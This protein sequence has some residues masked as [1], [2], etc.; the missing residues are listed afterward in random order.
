MNSTIADLQSKPMGRQ[1][2]RILMNT[3]E[4]M[5]PS[6]GDATDVE[7]VSNRIMQRMLM[8]MPLR[9]LA[10]LSGSMNPTMV[11][12]MVQVANGQLIRGLVN[13]LRGQ[14][15]VK[16]AAKAQPKTA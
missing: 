15:Q 3:V 12:G 4:K 8:D 16:Q 11:E 7:V 14:R 13:L 5:Y 10:A 2:F 9:S 1:V 6:S